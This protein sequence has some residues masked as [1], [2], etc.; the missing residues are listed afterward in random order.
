[1]K[2]LILGTAFLFILCSLIGGAIFGLLNTPEVDSYESQAQVQADDYR[3]IENTYGDGRVFYTLEF[4]HRG[5]WFIARDA[6][7]FGPKRLKI[8]NARSWD[9]EEVRQLMCHLAVEDRDN[10]I[11]KSQVIE[12]HKQED[13]APPVSPEQRKSEQIETLPKKEG[14]KVL[15]PGSSRKRFERR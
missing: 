6:T 1:M 9:V 4:M 11:I 10:Q 7:I 15:P 5:E 2:K 8:L 14:L 13:L 3:I 12:S